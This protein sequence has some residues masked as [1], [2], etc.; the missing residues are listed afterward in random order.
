VSLGSIAKPDSDLSTTEQRNSPNHLVQD[1]LASGLAFMLLANVG[2]RG[3]GFFRNLSFCRFLDEGSL[4][5]WALA[6]SFL[7]LAAPLAVLGLPGTF[8]KLIE[9][10]RL[11]RQL[12]PFL[13]RIAAVSS[14]G[15]VLVS[16]LLITSHQDSSSWIFGAEIGI[17][18]MSVVV[19]A[20]V[21][22]VLFNT[23]TELLNGLRKGRVVS[24][25]H[26]VNSLT[27][28]AFSVAGLFLWQD[29]RS[30]L[31][32]FALASLCGLIPSLRSLM[33]VWRESA[34]EHS[35]LSHSVMWNRVVPFA[36]SIWVMN[37]L[38]NLF[39]VIDR[40]MLLYLA[41]SQELGA[42]LVGQF[43]SARILPLLLTSLTMMLSSMLLPYL[44]ADW[45]SG[46]KH[47][48]KDAL[49]LTSKLSM[50]FFFLLSI[51]SLAVAPVLFNHFLEG[52]FSDGLAIMPIALAH[53]CFL[54]TGTLLQNYFW[55]VEKGRVVGFILAIGL[56]INIV[57][58]AWWV[59]IYGLSGAMSATTVAGGAILMLTWGA[60]YC[61]GIELDR[62]NLILCLLPIV[63][64]FGALPSMAIAALLIVLTSRSS[65]LLSTE[66]K[67]RIDDAIVPQ[68]QR[69]GLPI[70]TLWHIG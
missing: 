70:Q 44:A 34:E 15:V 7:L 62:T 57:L 1:S 5:L 55:C 53:C 48:V 29:W 16:I 22:V 39:D 6:S 69:I 35:A 24:A 56:L 42:A 8:G 9:S 68:L 3:I 25:M 36:L 64:L 41:E 45:E 2:Q 67:R 37:L 50:S 31:I 20:L 38:A 52:R 13:L 54:A 28:T 33:A 4:G 14:I 30:V 63:L 59:P 23:T 17:G 65:L 27:F 21:S 60:L 46:N 10:Y 66:E 32:A 49:Q 43:H 51:L 40:Y 12:R 58:N 19:F 26:T 11:R 61:H 18:S 47:R